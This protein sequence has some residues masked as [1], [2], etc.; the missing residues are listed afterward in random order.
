MKPQYDLGPE[1]TVKQEVTFK[2]GL[3]IVHVPAHRDL[4]EAELFFDFENDFQLVKLVSE[5]KCQ[6]SKIDPGTKPISFNPNQRQSG[7]L[8]SSSMQH[9]RV[10]RL[11]TRE[12]LTN[13]SHLRKEMQTACAGF[14]TFWVD[15][16]EENLYYSARNYLSGLTVGNNKYQFSPYTRSSL[17]CAHG[18]GI[19]GSQIQCHPDCFYQLC[20][21][22]G[23][24]WCYYTA[25]HCPMV[26]TSCWQHLNNVPLNCRPCCSSPKVPCGTQLPYCGCYADGQN[27]K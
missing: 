13:L 5:R 20:N 3:Q 22:N 26:T 14:P 11:E 25:V 19:V 17:T 2:D 15:S 1:S 21:P 27:G 24:K 23:G 7:P 6:L 18:G 16:V 12:P 8:D 9:T 10:V 4:E